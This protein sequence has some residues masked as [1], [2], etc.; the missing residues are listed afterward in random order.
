[1]RRIA[2]ITLA[3]G[4]VLALAGCPRTDGPPMERPETT[5]T[6]TMTKGQ[7]TMITG[8]T[9]TFARDGALETT[10]ASPRVTLAANGDVVTEER[11]S[12]SGAVETRKQ[13]DGGRLVEEERFDA[14]GQLDER[15]AYRYDAGGHLAEEAM[16]FGDGTPHGKW[17]HHRD[18]QHRLVRR[19]FVKPDGTVAATETY[20]YASDG[21]TA[22]MVRAHVGQ[23]KY[24]YDD[25]GRVLH[26]EGGPASGDD[27]DQLAIDYA[28]DA[29]HRLVSEVARGPGGRLQREIKVVY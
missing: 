27:L 22:T 1:M 2:H 11:L 28:Y 21:K 16:T 18:D 4:A 8:M 12:A 20:T 19:D 13:F 3:L 14:G 29:R 6:P 9:K 5:R 24:R 23:W 7:T 17:I 25:A 15:I 26:E 10:L